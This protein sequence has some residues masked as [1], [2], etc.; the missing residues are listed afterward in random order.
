M[1]E[2][3]SRDNSVYAQ[4]HKRTDLPKCLYQW[5]QGIEIFN[6]PWAD[7]VQTNVLNGLKF[8]ASLGVRMA[9]IHT[10]IWHT[11]E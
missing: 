11:Y 8:P 7:A 5:R 3:L 1:G 4:G 9:D 6:T 2:G 10:S